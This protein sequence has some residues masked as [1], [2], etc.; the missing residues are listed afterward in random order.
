MI[1]ARPSR[2][3]LGFD[4]TPMIDVVLQLIIFFMFT[5]QFGQLTRTEVILPEEPG[6]QEVAPAKPDLVIDINR[7]GLLLVDSRQV[8]IEE[9]AQI[10]AAEVE[11]VGGDGSSVDVLIRADRDAGASVLNRLAGELAKAGVR[12]WKLATSAP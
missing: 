8:S 6:E 9:A 10:A 11:R 7:E 4:M 1:F 3:P 2:R 12:R 5:N